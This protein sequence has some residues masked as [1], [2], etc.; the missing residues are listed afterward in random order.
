VFG[1]LSFASVSGCF[2]DELGLFC[3]F[4]IFSTLAVLTIPLLLF[5]PEEEDSDKKQE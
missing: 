5:M 4:C 3:M 1:K 2:I